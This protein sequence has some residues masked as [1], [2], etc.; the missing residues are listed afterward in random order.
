MHRR[1]AD[2]ASDR[3]LS[4]FLQTNTRPPKP[5]K[6]GVTEIRGPYYTPMGPRYLEDIFQTMAPYIDSLKSAGGSFA[7]MPPAVV[8]QMIQ[9]CH[10]NKV[11]VSTGGFIEYVLTHGPRAVGNFMD[12]CKS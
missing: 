6:T 10:D 1:A 11:T 7:L 9:L 3:C 12:E 2:Q 8:R 5:R 4:S